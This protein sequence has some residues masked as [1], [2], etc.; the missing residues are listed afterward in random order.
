MRLSS[1]NNFTN[2]NINHIVWVNPQQQLLIV[3]VVKKINS[4]KPN[5]KE[6]RILWH[7]T[8][9]GCYLDVYY[10]DIR[11][12]VRISEWGDQVTLL[13]RC[14]SMTTKFFC[15]FFYRLSCCSLHLYNSSYRK[16][17]IDEN[18]LFNGCYFALILNIILEL[19]ENMV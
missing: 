4:L 11:M 9:W 7:S 10:F 15:L 19:N 13:K 5:S 18:W 1:D 16:G 2:I 12:T 17:S 6:Q 8:N 14:Y 3:S